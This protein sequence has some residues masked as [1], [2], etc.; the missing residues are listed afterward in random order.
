VK[1]KRNQLDWAW[2]DSPLTSEQTTNQHDSTVAHTTKLHHTQEELIEMS[3]TER[4]N[5]RSV[6]STTSIDTI[7][8]RTGGGM[9]SSEQ[10]RETTEKIIPT[11]TAG[12]MI[13]IEQIRETTEKIIP[14]R[15]GGGTTSREQIRET[16]ENIMPMRTAGEMTSR[17]QIKETP[18][19]IMPMR[20]AGGMTSREQIRETTEKITPMK[21]AGDFS[22]PPGSLQ[23]QWDLKDQKWDLKDQNVGR[24]SARTKGSRH[25]LMR[26]LPEEI[27][28]RET[29]RHY[30]RAHAMMTTFP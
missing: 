13:S 4:E 28:E 7:L 21:T 19:K 8:M 10:I 3:R 14:M 26:L 29:K 11:R 16:T 20:T 2:I 24:V 23:A 22:T 6:R 9:T 17:E 27:Q 18:E 5:A 1:K 25:L 15:T 12:G 30:R